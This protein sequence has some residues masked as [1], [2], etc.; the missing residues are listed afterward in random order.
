MARGV[1]V[2]RVEGYAIIT[3]EAGEVQEFDTFTCPHCNGVCIIR[4]GSGKQRGYCNMCGGPTCGRPNCMECV[5]FLKK[6]ER[7]ERRFELRK[8]M[9][10]V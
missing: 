10:R 8:A 4:P 5:P 3:G 1:H 6:L 2:G 9:D 7:H